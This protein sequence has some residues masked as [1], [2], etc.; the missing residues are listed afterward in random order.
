MNTCRYK[1]GVTDH[2]FLTACQKKEPNK[3]MHRK[4]KLHT[5][6]HTHEDSLSCI[7]LD[8][9]SERKYKNSNKNNDILSRRNIT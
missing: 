5:L 6:S 7:R 9:K 8:H 1:Y 2:N 4:F 3:L